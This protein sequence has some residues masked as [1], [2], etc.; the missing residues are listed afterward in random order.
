MY[1]ENSGIDFNVSVSNAIIT[2]IICSH[3]DEN[4]IWKTEQASS[5]VKGLSYIWVNK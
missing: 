4:V 2:S 1:D 3:F 5:I